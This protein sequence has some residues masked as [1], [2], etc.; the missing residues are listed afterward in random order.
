MLIEERG[1]DGR[2]RAG[3][4]FELLRGAW[5][6]LPGIYDLPLLRTWTGFRPMSLH[7]EPVLGPSPEVEDLWF[8]TGHGRN[9]VLLTAVTALELAPSLI[10]GELS[11]P[12]RP[13]SA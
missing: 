13:F 3:H 12:L 10:R 1:F 8:A 6:T 2:Q 7:N 9:G 5:E 11:A 4:V